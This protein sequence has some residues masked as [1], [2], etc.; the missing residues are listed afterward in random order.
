MLRCR[1]TGDITHFWRIFCG[2]LD[3]PDARRDTSVGCFIYFMRRNGVLQF[4]STFPGDTQFFG[5]RKDVSWL[6]IP[7]TDTKKHCISAVRSGMK[8][9]RKDNNAFFMY[10]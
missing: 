3:P 4:Y 2:D 8:W 6:R 7:Q 1:G 10:R 5:T 9:R